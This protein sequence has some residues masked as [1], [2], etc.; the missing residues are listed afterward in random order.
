MSLNKSE[1]KKK[2]NFWILLFLLIGPASILVFVSK[3]GCEHK[4]ETLS[5]YGKVPDFRF[6]DI[7]GNSITKKDFK[8]NVVLFSV[9]QESCPDSCSIS[10]WHLNQMIY[11]HIRK[12]PKKLAHVKLISIITD[13]KGNGVDKFQTIFQTINDQVEQYNPKQW[14]LVRGDAKALYNITHNKQ[15][16]LQKGEKYYGGEA[17]QELLLL[18][19]KNG[20]LRMVL[21]GKTEGMI[22]KMKDYIALL[23]KQYDKEKLKK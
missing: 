23:D 3:Q 10:F 20:H 4:F 11:Q 8:D 9:L 17:F 21:N 13:G 7:N 16:L 19:D 12:N 15:S 14:M 1:R 2:R 22:R 5:D 18:M 6:I